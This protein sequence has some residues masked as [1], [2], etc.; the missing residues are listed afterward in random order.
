MQRV[1]DKVGD[2]E[3]HTIGVYRTSATVKGGRRFS[4][5]AL[6]VGGD[7]NGRVGYGYGKANEVPAAIEKAQK[8]AKR[9][10]MPIARL[11]TT[12][13]HEVNGTFGS[14]QVRMLPA[15][16]GTG[17][18]AGATVRAVLEMAGVTDCM[19]KCYG[20]TNARNVVKAIFDGLGALRSPA[21]VAQLRGVELGETAI[22][23]RIGKAKTTG[24]PVGVGA[25][26]A[27]ASK[28]DDAEPA[29]EGDE[30]SASN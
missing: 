7:R 13:H 11:G 25:S 6:V 24:V 18:V 28:S 16:P 10:L 4:F 22:A 30:A 3:F 19:T 17:V 26:E 14:A 8:E 27:D 12:I 5:G 23:G 1:Q 2:I 15:T 20:S 29:T 21:E 9:S